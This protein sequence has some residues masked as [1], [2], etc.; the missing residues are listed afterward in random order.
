MYKYFAR[1]FNL[2]GIKFVNISERKVLTNNSELTVASVADQTGLSLNW[3]HISMDRFSHDVAHMSLIIR[4][5]VF[6]TFD[7]V[8][9]K[10]ACSAIATS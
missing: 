3:W 9:L 6:G 5:S 7:Q 8:R 4:K 2:R 1:I 10:P